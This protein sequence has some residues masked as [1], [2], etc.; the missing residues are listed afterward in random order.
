MLTSLRYVLASPLVRRISLLYARG[1][2][3]EQRRCTDQE[4]MI[5]FSESG[6]EMV[7]YRACRWKDGREGSQINRVSSSRCVGAGACQGRVSTQGSHGSGH[8][9][10]QSTTE[11][12]KWPCQPCAKSK[13][14]IE[15][16]V[17]T[18]NTE[19]IHYTLSPLATIN[20]TLNKCTCLIKET[21]LPLWEKVNAVV[22]MQHSNSLLL[23]KAPLDWEQQRK[24]LFHQPF[25]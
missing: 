13:S 14:D 5:K 10:T 11:T 23:V 3:I 4:R 1:I 17:Q 9:Q 21:Q 6:S 12:Q 18:L 22:F 19:K 15:Y 20:S 2:Y 8:V 7:D 16:H 25:H 24:H